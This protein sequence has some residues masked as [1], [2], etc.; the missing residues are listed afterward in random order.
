MSG[1]LIV[2]DDRT[3]LRLFARMLRDV[4]VTTT[5]SDSEQALT[6]ARRHDPHL[7]IV[8]YQMPAPDGME[9]IRRLRQDLTKTD[10]PIIMLTGELEKTVRH[11]ALR[12]GA[13]AFLTKPVDAIELQTYAQNLVASRRSRI[14]SSRQAERIRKLYNV[15]SSAG[16]SAKQ[17][18][19]DALT[20]GLTLI[21]MEAGFIA[22]IDGDVLVMRNCSGLS[23]AIAPGTRIPL[24]HSL[25]RHAGA[26][27]V[28]AIDD[29]N[30]AP[31]NSDIARPRSA[32]FRSYI[33]APFSV[34]GKSYGALGFYGAAP[35]DPGFDYADRD[36]VRLMGA[37]V[38]S[39]VEYGLQEERLDALAFYD[40]LTG[41]PNRN[42]CFD[43]LERM[44]VAAR[45]HDQS[46]A[47]LFL[48]LDG[49]KAVND[50]FGHAAGD[51]V[52][53]MVARRLENVIR[54]SDTLARL[55]GDEFVVL[56]AN[57][58]EP[59]GAQTLANR[60][61]AAMEEPFAGALG[62]YRVGT[63]IGVSLY[64][65][66]GANAGQLVDRADE[67]LYEAKNAGRNVARF[68]GSVEEDAPAAL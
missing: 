47:V 56:A 46:F 33:A 28:L 13:S 38:S 63:S 40:A 48:D 10:T 18:L 58:K 6:W 27:T 39:T 31:W 53:K 55:G 5:F 37:L 41:L 61:L 42:L 24:E 49:F 67:A 9:F 68:Y 7:I 50:T 19:D 30:A 32:A 23:D 2:D 36:F 4:D 34:A 64:P 65:G 26:T 57:V 35:R 25:F 52:L 17:R 22:A 11:E 45:R 66:D 62:T 16:R 12:C 51:E 3:T 14:A 29:L 43:R 1:I 54:E 44:L 21:G 60:I 59:A 8:D 15:A 20:V